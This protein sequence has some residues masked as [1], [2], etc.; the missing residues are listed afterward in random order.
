M[1]TKMS[2]CLVRVWIFPSRLV[3]GSQSLGQRPSHTAFTAQKSEFIIQ[4]KQHETKDMLKKQTLCTHRHT[5]T[6][7][8]KKPG[9]NNLK[10][11]WINSPILLVAH[12]TD[13]LNPFRTYLASGELVY[14]WMVHSS[15]EHLLCS[16]YSYNLSWISY[17][18]TD[19]STH[20]FCQSQWN[21]L[22]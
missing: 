8:D 14:F 13:G 15:F 21:Y 1:L 5:H 19:L 2:P 18:K 20:G 6:H 10:F 11:S 17:M 7:R 22:E 16:P 9:I 4:W 3:P 12:Q